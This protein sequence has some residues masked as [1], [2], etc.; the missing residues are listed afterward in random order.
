VGGSSPFG[1]T[2]ERQDG[3]RKRIGNEEFVVDRIV[4][5]I[6]HRPAK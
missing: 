4:S 3:L 5:N 1:R 6:V 2:P